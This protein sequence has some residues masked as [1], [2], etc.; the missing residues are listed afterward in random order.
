MTP[1]Q[2]T[3]TE[4]DLG[5][6]EALG[7]GGMALVYRLPDLYLPD[8]PAGQW[9]YKKYK[10][11]ARPVSTFAL[12]QLV[13]SCANRDPSQRTAIERSANWPVRVVVDSNHGASGVVL[14]L[15]EDEFFFELHKSSGLVDLKPLELQFL[16]QDEDY[17]RRV[18]VP[19]VSDAQRREIV[20]SLTYCLA[21]L[22]R[23]EYVYGDI[24]A[25]NFIISLTPRVRVK[26]VDCDAIRVR[27]SQ[28]A[29]GK[30]P[31]SPDWEPPECVAAKRQKDHVRY[32]IQSKATDSYK[33]GLAILRLLTPGKGSSVNTDPTRARHVLPAHLYRLLELSLSADPAQ[34]PSPKDW[35]QGLLR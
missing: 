21:V 8:T 29:T 22:H 32:A 13:L 9:V 35:Y 30:Q 1:D 10:T 27:G 12:Q 17:C 24:S 2:I 16:M 34:R 19:S 6:R 4:G 20:R 26:A 15:L 23:A 33:L 5:P 3:L 28:A 31:H 11:K 25:R 7:K 18:G 14:P